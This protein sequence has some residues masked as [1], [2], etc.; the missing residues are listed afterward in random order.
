MVTVT[1]N[2]GLT[3]KLTQLLSLEGF[4]DAYWASNVDDKKSISGICVFL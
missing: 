1:I 2:C 4:A 3:F